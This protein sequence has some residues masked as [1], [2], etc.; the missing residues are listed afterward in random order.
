[1]NKK[2][3]SIICA[4][5]LTLCA[6]VGGVVFTGMQTIAS[7][8]QMTVSVESPTVGKDDEV[9]VLVTAS[10]GEAMSYVKA[11]LTYDPE[12]LELVGTST[13][14]ATGA[15]GEIQIIETLAYGET[16]RTY[17]LTFKALEVGATDISLHDAYIEQ[18]ES[19]E[20]VSLEGDYAS[21][22]VVVNT[23]ISEDAR[24]KELMIAGVQKLEEKFSP[25]VF[26]YDVE[27]GVDME[28][29][30]YS[31]VPMDEE[32]VITAPEDLM[33]AIG[34][35]HFE[36]L[37]TAPA[38]NTQTYIINVTR[39]DHELESETETETETESE[40][41]AE[42]ESAIETE[43]ETESSL[44]S[45]SAPMPETAAGSETES[46]TLGEELLGAPQPYSVDETEPAM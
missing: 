15:N 10:S 1:M 12:K 35:N 27:V 5:V 24:I 7:G 4:T 26:E 28:M 17:E 39:L 37:V 41:E 38:G 21:L 29:F 43:T 30:I 11:D 18:Y 42:T 2:I 8:A 45:E 46:E 20:M 34:E 6:V 31:A 3:I 40:T 9:R 44:E 22:E 19:L 23:D 32:S 14:L 25:D 33:L 16:E 13:D 36:I